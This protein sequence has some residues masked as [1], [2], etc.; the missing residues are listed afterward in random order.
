MAF[1][2]AKT[3]V[4]ARFGL[5]ILLTAGFLAARPA[6]VQAQETE[7]TIKVN[8]VSR[9]FVV[10]LPLG[11]DQ[12][13]HYPVVII[14]HGENQDADD[15]ARITH[16]SQFAEKN[17]I[18]AVYPNGMRH[19]WN[20]EVQAEQLPPPMPRRAGRRGWGGG[21]PGGMQGGGQSPDQTKNRPEPASDVAFLNQLLDQ[22][23]LKFSADTQRIYAAGLGDGGFMALRAGCSVS[24]RIA[25]L[26]AVSAGFPKT[27]ICLPER[28][29][30]ALFINGTDDPVVSYGGGTFKPGRFRVLSA[31]D[32]AKTWAKVNRCEEKPTQGKLP[33]A[34]RDSGGK[35]IKTFTFSACQDNAGVLLYALKNGG[36]TWPG[37]EQYESEKAVGKVSHSLD[38]N[39]TI[40]GFF[41]SKKLAD[42]GTP[43]K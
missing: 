41:V 37:G 28:A 39:E 40:W 23:A 8:D 29:V 4:R 43:K 14:F 42:S 11:Y 22:L 30:P 32:S 9:T 16:F 34:D 3:N 6:F 20:I 35:E 15:V 12:E 26:A 18:I 19:Q 5:A 2:P 27:M 36:H 38:G 10:H 1:N 7:E 33:P 21:Y 17:G 24:S 13:T 31:E 25:A